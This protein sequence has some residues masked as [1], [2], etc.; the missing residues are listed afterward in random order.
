MKYGGRLRITSGKSLMRQALFYCEIMESVNGRGIKYAGNIYGM[1][2][3]NTWLDC[4]NYVICY[5][6]DC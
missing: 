6:N 4:A 3:N 1:C 5:N 2:Y